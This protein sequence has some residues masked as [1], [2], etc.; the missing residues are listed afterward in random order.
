VAALTARWLAAHG[1]AT[2]AVLRPA[3]AA[4]PAAAAGLADSEMAQ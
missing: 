4:A 2:E 1:A 3:D